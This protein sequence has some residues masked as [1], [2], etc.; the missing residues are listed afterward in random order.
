MNVKTMEG[1]AGASTSMSMISI[2]MGV[3]KEAENKG[4]TEKMKRA[5]GYAAGLVDQAE[6]YSEKTSEGME[7]DAKE[8]K[9]K[10]KLRQEELI[11]ARKAEREE[12]KK[13]ENA[14][15]DSVKISEEGKYQAQMAGSPT[16]AAIDSS[17]NAVYDKSGGTVEPAAEPGENVN[18]SV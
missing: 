8:A 2:P 14:G 9:E 6:E 16:P 7:L 4:D 12:Q 13:Q 1:L 17:Q 10:E 18:V 5:L 11:E 15:F 3:A